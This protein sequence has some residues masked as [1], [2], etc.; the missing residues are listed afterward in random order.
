M[1][2][3]LPT[4]DS[5]QLD[6]P[7]SLYDKFYI[8]FALMYP[9]NDPQM[10]IRTERERLKTLY[11]LNTPTQKEV[12]SRKRTTKIYGFGRK[13]LTNFDL[14]YLLH[15]FLCISEQENTIHNHK[16]CLPLDQSERHPGHCNSFLNASK[17]SNDH[18]CLQFCYE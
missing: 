6:L 14:D 17:R 16:R 12:W 18:C 2:Y 10:I 15:S 1:Y 4:Q 3:D 7:I 5:D 13:V 9:E 8:K 11:S